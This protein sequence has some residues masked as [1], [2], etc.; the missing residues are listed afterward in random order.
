MPGN[1]FGA[2][3]KTSNQKKKNRLRDNQKTIKERKWKKVQKNLILRGVSCMLL[4]V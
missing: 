1:G 4:K 3:W 2:A